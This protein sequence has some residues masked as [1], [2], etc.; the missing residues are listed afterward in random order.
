MKQIDARGRACPEPVL[1]AKQGLKASP[2]GIEVL[3]DNAVA[4]GNV[5]RFAQNAGYQ[6]QSAAGDGDTHK[7]TITK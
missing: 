7:L 6:V 2:A 1:M 4:L 5:T 3:V